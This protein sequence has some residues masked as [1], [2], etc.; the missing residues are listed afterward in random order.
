MFF[1]IFS[2]IFKRRYETNYGDRQ[3]SARKQ[4][5]KHGEHDRKRRGNGQI[6]SGNFDEQICRHAAYNEQKHKIFVKP[7]E[8]RRLLGRIRLLRLY[9]L[10]WLRILFRLNRLLRLRGL[11]RGSS[12]LRRLLKRLDGRRG[13]LNCFCGLF[14]LLDRRSR[15]SAFRT[16]F[17]SVRDLRAAIL[18]KC[19]IISLRG[20]FTVN[21]RSRDRTFRFLLRPLKT[22]PT[23]NRQDSLE[24]TLPSICRC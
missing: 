12:L 20:F 22:I 1:A 4:Q 21:C 13:R 10:L 9:G 11:C 3:K 15:H 8:I 7:S 24:D 17:R 23:K 2:A 6:E 5:S 19:H 16:K 14:R 18:T